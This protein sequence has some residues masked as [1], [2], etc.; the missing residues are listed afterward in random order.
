MT[1]PVLRPYQCR[2]IEQLREHL[3]AKRRRLLLVAP[4]G[5]GKTLL[6]TVV[7]A[8]RERSSGPALVIVHRAELVTQTL[9]K[10]AAVGLEAGVL[11]GA[12]KRADPSQAVQVASIQT[13]HRR[14][15]RGLPPAGLVVYDEVHHCL[16]RTS[17][18]VLDGYPDATLLGLTA[19]PFRADGQGLGDVFEGLVVAA[20]TRE[21]QALGALVPVDCYAYDAPDLH[22]IPIVAGDYSP[23]KLEAACNTSVLVGS[24]VREYMA[25]AAGRRAIV[26]PV[27]CE[28]SRA[29]VAEFEAAGVRA[30]HIDWATPRGV[31][32][33]IIDDFR[34]GSTMALSS[35]G[36]LTEGF[37]APAAEVC[38][39]AR[40]TRSLG[41]L[42][43]MAGRVLR[44]APG[45][46]R[47]LIHDHGGNLF[48]H[49]FPD[50]DREF[51]LEKTTSAPRA[52]QACVDCGY[53]TARWP[54]SGRC[55]KCGTIQDVPA[56][57][58]ESVERRKGKQ[59]VDGRRVGRD[60]IQR[61]IDA[62]K[63]RGRDLTRAQAAKVASATRQD[64]AKEFLRLEQV[65]RAK[66]LKHG[67]PAQAFRSTFGH[68]P[69][70][71]PE[72][73]EAA[74]AADRP[75]IPLPPRDEPRG[76]IRAGVTA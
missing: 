8:F 6:A 26:F 9:E 20:T 21:L 25:H 17:R 33:E 41:L 29:L 45:K 42:L 13:L 72:E 14:I 43:Q 59:Q 36:V 5:A 23:G 2:A 40:P 70:F 37:D 55:P 56:E 38:V 27:G 58:R 67:F 3:R 32:A 28:H 68:W 22:A 10:L 61:V 65:M 53:L 52:L 71:R 11:M 51:T 4:C 39:L 15:A 64:K 18:A 75:F 12:D 63:E 48:R 44:P 73:L 66:N 69:R 60:E 54:A 62:A 46:T 30:A 74:T 35:V 16:A 57:Q 47:A 7:A 34:S 49:G 50:D 1:P 76:T 31:R 24:V 19:T